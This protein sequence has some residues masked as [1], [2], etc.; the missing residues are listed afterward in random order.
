[1]I[2]EI[3]E[4][5]ASELSSNRSSEVINEDAL[6]I[7]WASVLERKPELRHVDYLQVD[8]EPAIISLGALVR[9]M[10]AGVRP[11]VVTFEHDAYAPHRFAGIFHQGRLVRTFSRQ[12]LRFLG[13]RLVAPNIATSSGKAFEDWYVYRERVAIS[14][15]PDCSGALQPADFLRNSGLERDYL[16][17]RTAQ[18]KV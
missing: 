11:T 12:L 1:M 14:A 4:S 16:Q 9:I 6:K 7:R 18:E 17:F 2:V 5:L 15:A 10:A 3:D 13:F 8:C